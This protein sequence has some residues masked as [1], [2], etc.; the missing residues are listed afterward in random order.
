MILSVNE[1]RL[2]EKRAQKRIGRSAP[3]LDKQDS[4]SGDE[5]DE[6]KKIVVFN[7]GEYLSFEEGR[8][9]I[10]MRLTCYCRHHQEKDGFWY[11]N[12][13]VFHATRSLNS[14]RSALF[15]V[16]WIAMVVKSLVVE[17]RLSCVAQLNFNFCASTKV[18]ETGND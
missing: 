4:S 7:C 15:S 8:V 1:G 16:H 11:A 12:D 5:A 17:H 6:D 18:C 3:S 2:Q 9:E 14:F 13:L 10:P